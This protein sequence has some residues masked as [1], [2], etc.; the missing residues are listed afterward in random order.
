M[1]GGYREEYQTLISFRL[2]GLARRK[3]KEWKRK[4]NEVNA[5]MTAEGLNFVCT[6]NW[7]E[8]VP[9]CSVNMFIKGLKTAKSE[10]TVAFFTCPCHNIYRVELL[11]NYT[12]K[13]TIL[14][15]LWNVGQLHETLIFCQQF[16]KSSCT[17]ATH[18]VIIY[19]IPYFV[20]SNRFSL[21]TDILRFNRE[22]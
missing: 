18:I 12:F 1:A 22:I 6:L 17:Y 8:N 3:K 19:R 13:S 14:V 16:W 20:S 4:R 7:T 15:S 10:K 2:S 21:N 5:K 11:S 9:T